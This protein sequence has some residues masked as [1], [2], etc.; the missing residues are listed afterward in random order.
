MWKKDK[1]RDSSR[2]LGLQRCWDIESHRPFLD[3][4]SVFPI[5]FP[6]D[7]V[8]LGDL[9]SISGGWL[10]VGLYLVSLWLLTPWPSGQPSLPSPLLSWSLSRLDKVCPWPGMIMVTWKEGFY[11]TVFTN[12]RNL[13]EITRH[14]LQDMCHIEKEINSKD[15]QNSV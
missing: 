5:N 7:F 14:F 11:A 3:P 9:A 12:S 4:Q 8:S 1:I 13:T 15:P 2:Y 6:E 10:F